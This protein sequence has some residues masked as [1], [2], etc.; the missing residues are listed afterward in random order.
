MKP[1]NE[2]I[3][4]GT[5]EAW[6]QYGLDPK[7]YARSARQERIVPTY[8]EGAGT[9]FT[10]DQLPKEVYF[11]HYP[12]FDNTQEFSKLLSVYDIAEDAILENDGY[13]LR[14]SKMSVK[15]PQVAASM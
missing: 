1:T 6:M 15:N 7:T 3:I 4:V 12:N 5:P 14:V 10:W 9:L 11:V 2:T 13:Q 8:V